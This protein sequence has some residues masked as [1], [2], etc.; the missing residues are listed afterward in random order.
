MSDVSLVF[1]AVGRDRGVNALLTRTASNVRASNAAAAASTIAMGGAMASAGAH[2]IALAGSAMSAVGAIGL[3]PAALAGAAAVIGAGR[4]VT[5]GLGEAWRATGQA[6]V[7]GGRAASGAGRQAQVSA[8]AV[9]D[10]TQALADAKR[11]EADATAAVNRARV[12]EKERLEDLGRALSGSVLDEEAATRAVA[13]AAQDLAVARAGGTNYDIE[14]ADLAY[15]Q[16]QQTLLDTKDR[17]GDLSKEQADGA[18]KGIE[19]SDAVQDALRRQQDAHRQTV[20]AA[21]QLADAQTKVEQASAG[22]VSGGFN[23]AAAALAKLSPNGRAVILMLRQLAPAWHAAAMAGQQATFANVAGDLKDLSDIYLPMATSWLIRMGGSFNVAIRQSM[24]LFKT[25]AAI[26]DVG[27]FTDNVALATDKLARAVKPVING[28][29]QWVTLGSSFLPGLAG[30]TLTIAQRFERWSIEMRKSG[31]AASWIKTGI[32]TLK[33]FGSIAGDVVMS[34]VAIFRAAGGGSASLDGLVRG[35]AA[36]RAWIESAQGQEKI[37]AVMDVLRGAVL[38]IGSLFG[39]AATQG[40]ELGQSVKILGDS[41]SFAV[42]HLGPL[43]KYLPALAA[44]Y[45]LLKH[46][47]ITAA[48]GLGV[49]AFQI[50]S[51]FAMARAIKAHT[52]ALKENT[53]SSARSTVAS[54]R[55][56]AAQNRGVIARGKSVIAMAAQKTAM[57]AA[58]VWTKAVTAGQWLLNAAMSANPLG[59]I[60]I[61]LVAVGV[62]LYLLW[63]RSET[64]RKIVKGAFN[65]VWGAIKTG[66]S[67][68]KKNWPLLLAIL[69]GPIGLATR[70]ISQNWDRIKAGA[71]AVKDWIAN[72]FNQVITFVGGLPGRVSKA[73]AYLWSRITTGASAARDHVVGKFTSLLR[74]VTGLPGRVSR[75]TS[76][77]FNGIKS[78]FRGA[79]NYVIGRWNNLSFGIPGFSFAGMSVPGFTLNTPNIP[80][81]AQGGIVPATPG[82]RL[83]VIGEGGEDEAVVPLSKLGSTVAAATGAGGSVRV[84]FDASGAETEFKRW[85]RKA[86]RVDNLLQGA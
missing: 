15:R 61:A 3:V 40:S 83:V 13:K 29:L 58:T 33:Q 51:Q 84:S 70:A 32:R 37:A 17:V 47:G 72:R 2:A 10:A 75:A 41:V 42:D 19:G 77:M 56:A 11:D 4:A 62:G 7:G 71:T 52:A 30:S 45:L 28:L 34:V 55:D 78:A 49:K 64:F 21:Q 73:T 39:S 79:I 50:A 68:V 16:A 12:E 65:A 22:A 6:A 60:V 44:G 27:T 48:V 63:T 36:M 66:W 67:W 38:A 74:A 76:G 59:L 54:N 23:P 43:V 25:K 20:R 80:Y 8:R 35:A 1:N 86:I 82:G 18:R 9:R 24:G 26:R 57:I 53:I 5:M 81:L 69:T 31:Q 14:E 46:T 85:I